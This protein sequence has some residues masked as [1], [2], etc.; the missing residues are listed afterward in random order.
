LYP[1][2]IGDV[3]DAGGGRGHGDGDGHAAEHAHQ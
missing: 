1:G 2:R 3:A